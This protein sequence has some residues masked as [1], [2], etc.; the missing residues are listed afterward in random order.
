MATI[1]KVCVQSGH[2]NMTSGATG[3]PLEQQRT[4]AIGLKLVDLLRANGF[5]VYHTDAFANNN[6][7]VTGQ[8]WDL[9]L[10]LHCDANYAGN[11]GGGFVDFPDPSVDSVSP[12]SK[13][14]KEAIESVYFTE[15][16][17]RN[18]PSRSNPNTKYYYM[19]S[20]LSAKTP[21]VII[22]MGE[23]IDPHD[24]VILNDVN[25][26]AQALLKGI[27][28]AF[29]L[30]VV[31]PPVDPCANVKAELVTANQTIVALKTEISNK[32]KV[33]T[34]KD[35]TISTLTSK[36]SQIKALCP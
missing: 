23:S 33:I 9:F 25:R 19:W 1:K 30:P 11:E 3:A 28:K 13:R 8:D 5:N 14:I 12:E 17:I 35:A 22:E 4:I 34:T 7:A 20:A 16:G 10:A 29:P 26:V 18:V 36:L 15:T 27:L 6:P 2:W 21:C 24:S 32:D 31:V